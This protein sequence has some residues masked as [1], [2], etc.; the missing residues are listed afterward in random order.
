MLFYYFS[1]K[2]IVEYINK[3]FEHYLQEELKIRRQLMLYKDT[4]IHVCL[5]FISPTGHGLK[6]LD[7]VTMKELSKKANVIPVIAKAD[8]TSKDELKRFKTKV[9]NNL[10]VLFVALATAHNHMF[11]FPVYSSFL[12]LF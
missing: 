9:K 11:S 12:T 10:V 1:A 3:Q 8:T 7:V 5:Y 4:R 6:A 2:V